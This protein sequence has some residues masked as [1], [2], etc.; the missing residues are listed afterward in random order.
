[1]CRSLEGNVEVPVLNGAWRSVSQLHLALALHTSRPGAASFPG[2]GRVVPSL[3]LC[4]PGVLFPPT[5]TL[6][7]HDFL[8][9]SFLPVLP[10]DVL[11]NLQA[12]L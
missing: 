6:H 2:K 9:Y 12:W 3:Q 8:E 11:L 7:P 10:G 4:S 1:M 5:P